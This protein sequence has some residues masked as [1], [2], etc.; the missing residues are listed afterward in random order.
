LAVFLV[1]KLRLETNLGAILCFSKGR[2]SGLPYQSILLVINQELEN[3]NLIYYWFPSSC[4]GTHLEAKLCFAVAKLMRMA[5][6]SL[7]GNAVP[8]PELGNQSKVY[9]QGT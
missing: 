3:E 5:K 6:Q 4:L 1:S 2:H 9:S 7:A 8:K